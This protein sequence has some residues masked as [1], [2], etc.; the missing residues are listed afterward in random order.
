M[1]FYILLAA[2]VGLASSAGFGLYPPV[3]FD[4]HQPAELREGREGRYLRV[5]N[6]TIVN[7]TTIAITAF[8]AGA[9]ALGVM[10]V[11]NDAANKVGNA[12]RRKRLRAKVQD[13]DIPEE[14]VDILQDVEEGVEFEPAFEEAVDYQ[15]GDDYARYEQELKEYKEAYA[16]YLE[17][18]KVWA[19]QYGQDP[20]PPETSF[21]SRSLRC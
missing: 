5:D 3:G 16:E 4:H 11:L 17:N 8:Y 7:A 2:L 20:E 10:S 14:T 12:K 6:T 13:V 1:K 15:Q 19:E 21:S 9:V 18:Y